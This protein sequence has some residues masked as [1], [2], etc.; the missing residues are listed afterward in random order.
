MP[1]SSQAYA[2]ANRL[3][4]DIPKVTPSSKVVGDLAQFMVSNG[5]SEENDRKKATT[6]SF[7]TS[8]VE[9]FQGYLG[10]PPHG[11][12]EPLRSD[13]ICTRSIPGSDKTSFE[14]R[15]GAEMED[16]DFEGTKKL[17]TEKWGSII[18]DCDV[19]SAAM[20]PA[21]FDEWMLKRKEF[22]KS[23]VMNL[24]TKN[25][26][27]GMERDEEIVIELQDG[28]ALNIK[29]I[30]ASE[31]DADGMTTVDFELNGSSRRI[32]MK[33]VKVE[34]SS[35]VRAK[36]DESKLGEVGASMQS[37]VV[38]TRVRSGDSVKAGDPLVV[39]SAMKMEVRQA[40][41]EK[42]ERSDDCILQQHKY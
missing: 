28:V 18:R 19:M 27:T 36:A 31:P 21:V 2:A 6:L 26:I 20:Y 1:R 42:E 37:V 10:V 30:N 15:P 41:S 8:I 7:P 11:F 32:R 12:P 14:G 23:G 4:G 17:L 13:I 38:E 9:Y 3:L 40:R 39:L 35:V 34:T 33:D 22:G 24:P 29:L 16:F 5:L 25:F